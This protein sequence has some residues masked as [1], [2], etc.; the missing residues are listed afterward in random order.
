[1]CLSEFW[2]FFGFSVVWG[3]VVFLGFGIGEYFDEGYGFDVVVW[4]GVG[5]CGC[6]L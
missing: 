1:M 5:D 4:V 6:F 2:V 3:L